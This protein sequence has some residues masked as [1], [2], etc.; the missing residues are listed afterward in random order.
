MVNNMNSN[1][2]MRAAGINAALADRWFLHISNACREFSIIK[3]ADLAMFIAQVKHESG[4][5]SRLIENLNYTPAALIATFGTHRIT[6]YQSEM[7]GRTAAHA[8]SQQGI[9]NLVYGGEWGRKNLGNIA[10]GDGWRYR[11]RGLI[12]MT[13]RANYSRTGDALG[14]SLTESPELL[15]R[16]E[17]AARSA[18]WFYVWR[19]CLKHSGDVNAITRLINGS[20]LGITERTAAY[21]RSLAALQ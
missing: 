21:E 7:L 8:A 1:Q 12:Q 20:T 19:G 15:E 16:V 13:G 10:Q 11:G 5:F 6:K 18:A 2:F 3:P 17:Y 9:A 4:G 14:L